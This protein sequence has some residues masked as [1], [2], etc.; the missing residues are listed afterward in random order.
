MT[1]MHSKW[2]DSGPPQ[3]ANIQCGAGVPVKSTG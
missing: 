1:T 2:S 3:G